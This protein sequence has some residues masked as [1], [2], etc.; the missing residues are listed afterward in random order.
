MRMRNNPGLSLIVLGILAIGIGFAGA[1]TT[2]AAEPSPPSSQVPQATEALTKTYLS[3]AFKTGGSG[4]ADGFIQHQ[5]MLLNYTGAATC[6]GCHPDEVH[7]FT[8]SNHYLW[9]GKLGAINDFCGYPD[10]NFG[11]AKLTNVSG[12]LLDGGCATCHAGLGAKPTL[13]NPRN[14]D[15]LTCHAQDYRR[16]AV[17]V[18]D[19]WRFVPDRTNMPAVIEI[20]GQPSRY[21]CLTCHV[22]AGGGG[23]NKRGDLS[24]ALV[25]PTP[26]VDVHMGNGMLCTDCHLEQDH[27]IAGTGSDMRIDEG[28]AMRPCSD[29]HTPNSDHDPDIQQH[30]ATVACQSCHIPAYAR[31]VSTDMFRDYRAVELNAR[32]LYEPAI[33]RG[34]NVIP[35]YA[36]WNGQNGFY[37]FGDPAVAGQAMA[38]PLGDITDGKLYPFKLHTAM[39]P[40]DPVTGAIIPAKA[41][42][43]FQTGDMDRAILTGATESSFSLTR[44]YTFVETTRW[45]GIY[46]EMPPASQALTCAECHDATD[47]IDFSALGYTPVETRNGVALCDSCHQGSGALDFYQIHNQHVDGEVIACAECHTFN[48]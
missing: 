27:R 38:W 2:Q 40:Q 19:G 7:Q 41:G 11:P 1:I 30:L 46:H 15:C 39:L 44:G 8:A 16:T 32:G 17:L 18:S 9:Q 23:N 20:Q 47:R 26:D 10:I 3:L 24:D 34:A 31:A 22:S 14:G 13:D 35:E 48:R 6:L 43:L 36:F 37:N 21:S 5:G 28:V 42:I 4:Q 12:A 45:M 29:C 25:N 33:L